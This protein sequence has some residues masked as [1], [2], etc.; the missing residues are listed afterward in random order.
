[1]TSEPDRKTT[2]LLWLNTSVVLEFDLRCCPLTGLGEDGFENRLDEFGRSRSEVTSNWSDGILGDR[3]RT[4]D[5]GVEERSVGDFGAGNF[6]S[7]T[8][9]TTIRQT[10]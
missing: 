3:V 9:V 6:A 8:C 1:L 4:G 7:V 10:L 2:L 5:L